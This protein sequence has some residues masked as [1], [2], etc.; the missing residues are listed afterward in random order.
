M[1]NKPNFLFITTLFIFAFLF[2]IIP[3]TQAATE[4]VAI[5]REDCSQASDSTLNCYTSLSAWEAAENRDLV[6]SDEIAVARIEGPWTN[7]D[8]SPVVID[9]WT[10]DAT[11]YIKIYTTLDARHGGKWDN[12]KYRLET[13]DSTA[14]DVN[15]N[16]VK[17]D[18][19]QISVNYSAVNHLNGIDFGSSAGDFSV[20]NSII[21]SVGNNDY[22]DGI[23]FK[24]PKNASTLKIWNNVIYGFNEFSSE[25]IYS[26]D[27]Y[28]KLTAYIYNN[29][30]YGSNEGVTLGSNTPVVVAKNNLIANV[31]DAGFKGTFS[32]NSSNNLSSDSTAPGTNSLANQTV[33]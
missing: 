31:V 25:G 6:A 9:G 17:I 26:D 22:G 33:S 16:Y 28:G 23:F 18:G 24:N 27:Y 13:T 1:K 12:T 7:P 32:P 29:T 15:E 8:T 21:K 19:L 11:H 2:L 3:S 30:V 5:V 4:S 10:T 20:S 14:V